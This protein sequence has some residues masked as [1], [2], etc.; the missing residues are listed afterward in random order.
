[1]KTSS[2]KAKGRKLCLETVEMILQ[3]FPE[4]EPGDLSVTSS[5]ATGE[6][7][8]LSPRAL[9]LLPLSIEAKNQERANFWAA[10]EQAKGHA[11][12]RGGE[13]YPALVA[14]RNRTEPLMVLR[15]EDFLRL[16]RLAYVSRIF[17]S[18]SPDLVGTGEAQGVRTQD[19]L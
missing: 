5:G 12:K 4:L 9:K 3:V 7:I 16:L 1:M 10:F 18:Q 2:C 13:T 19:P 14:R 8:R 17:C 11:S 15:L 6:D